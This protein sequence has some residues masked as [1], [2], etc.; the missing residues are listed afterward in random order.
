VI[1]RPFKEGLA[2]VVGCVVHGLGVSVAPWNAVKEAPGEV[3]SVPFGNPQ[4]HRHVGLLQRQ[5]SPRTTVIDRLHHHLASFSGEF[6]I[7]G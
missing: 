4:I 7:P 3:V 1:A 5:T 6:G 2:A